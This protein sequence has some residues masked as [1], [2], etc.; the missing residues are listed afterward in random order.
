M[1]E[2]VRTL[3]RCVI[4]YGRLQELKVFG[5]SNVEPPGEALL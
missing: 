3:Q 2:S 4:I 5:C 1:S